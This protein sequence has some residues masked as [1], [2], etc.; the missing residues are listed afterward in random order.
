MADEVAARAHARG[1]PPAPRF[2]AGEWVKLSAA[3]LIEQ[4]GFAKGAAEGAVGISTRHALA[5]VN[6]GGAS[7]SQLLAFAGKVRRAVRAEFGVDLS[8][9]PVLVGFS[10][11]E[12]ALIQ[13]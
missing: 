13:S 6:R 3:W 5:L 11:D 9:E 7:A 8:V 4:S 10:S 1:A 12:L 2:P